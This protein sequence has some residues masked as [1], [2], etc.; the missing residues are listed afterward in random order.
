M[1]K[2]QL[3]GCFMVFAL[4][5]MLFAACGGDN[6]TN[7][8]NGSSDGGGNSGNYVLPPA[9]ENVVKLVSA[10][11]LPDRRWQYELKCNLQLVSGNLSSPGYI[12]EWNTWAPASGWIQDGWLH[13]KLNCYNGD[14]FFTFYGNQANSWIDPRLSFYSSSVSNNL[15]ILFKDGQIYRGQEYTAPRPVAQCDDYVGLRKE[16]ASWRVYFNLNK[17]PGPPS[18]AYWACSAVNNRQRQPIFAIDANGWASTLFAPN[19][20][21]KVIE[22]TYGEVEQNNGQEYLPNVAGLPASW[23]FYNNAAAA[24]RAKLYDDGTAVPTTEPVN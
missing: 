2:Q 8:F 6:I 1:K 18:G 22:F 13:F 24:F 16:G 17:V 10:V 3:A 12:A 23:Y 7:I 20:S 5:T 21:P 14:Y 15:Y 4:F 11:Q 19:V 9:T